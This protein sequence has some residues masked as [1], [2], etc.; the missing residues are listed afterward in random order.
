M[1][2]YKVVKIPAY[3]AIG[4]KWEGS[5]SEISGLKEV[6]QE[7]GDRREEL[8]HI[9][10]PVV[11]LG[12]SYH[13]RQDGFTHYSAYEV[14][15]EQEVPDGMIEI[16]IPEMTYLV[17]NHKKGGN[18]GKTYDDI[19]QY[20]KE[21]NYEPYRDETVPFENLPIKHEK[22]PLDRDLDDPHF[23]ILIPIEKKEKDM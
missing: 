3:R 17:T 9:V 20:L 14:T 16:D 18:I 13:T 23:E 6:I 11:Q 12:L 15:R 1:E 4:L 10:A 5:W 21:S 22:Y 19:A 7:A 8:S 2:K